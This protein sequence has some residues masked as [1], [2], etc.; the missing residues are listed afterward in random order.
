MPSVLIEV[1][2]PSKLAPG[3][4][5]LLIFGCASQTVSY[6]SRMDDQTI[7]L[8]KKYARADSAN[9]GIVQPIAH[10]FTF[11]KAEYP[12]A[13][14]DRLS[15]ASSDT[16]KN[17]ETHIEDIYGK[18][19][20]GFAGGEMQFKEKYPFNK[21]TELDTFSAGFVKVMAGNRIED[22]D[23]KVIISQLS[24]YTKELR[25]LLSSDSSLLKRFDDGLAHLPEKGKI[26]IILVTNPVEAKADHVKRSYAFTSYGYSQNKGDS[27]RFVVTIYSKYFGVISTS[28]MMHE[29]VHAVV[30]IIKVSPDQLI[31]PP[32]GHQFVQKAFKAFVDSSQD[33]PISEGIAESISQKYN[34]IY[35]SGYFNPVNENLVWLKK[36]Y[37]GLHSYSGIGSCYYGWFC[38]FDGRILSL[39]QSHSFVDFLIAQ[40]GYAKVIRLAISSPNEENYTQLFNKSRSELYSEW[41]KTISNFPSP[42]EPADAP[43]PQAPDKH[44]P[45]PLSFGSHR[46]PQRA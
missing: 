8:A 37:G 46:P 28:T 38:S 35:N 33:V 25:D 26:P 40:Y 29:L 1:A 11:L 17:L 3:L 4:F 22:S 18:C 42:A 19:L 36:Q 41:Q 13:E 12:V 5:A 21:F 31:I 7:E 6:R 32:S 24:N 44:R 16:S 43:Q 2:N 23:R 39:Y 10:I 45:D 20:Y 15:A 27:A 9:I 14:W 30:A 34:P